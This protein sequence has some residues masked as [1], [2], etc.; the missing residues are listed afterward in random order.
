MRKH[1]CR[2]CGKIFFVDESLKSAYCT[3]C[4][5]VNDL[6]EKDGSVVSVKYDELKK[7]I[8]KIR[9]KEKNK[10]TDEKADTFI[11]LWVTVIYHGRNSQGIFSRKRAVKEINRFWKDREIANILDDAQEY[12]EK[13][14]YEQLYDSAL[15][16]YDACKTDRHYGSKL[17]D[18]VK[19]KPDEIAEKTASDIVKY[20]FRYLLGFDDIMYRDQII[21]AAWFSFDPAFPSNGDILAEKIRDLTEEEQNELNKILK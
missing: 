3:F 17:F 18:I 6:I 4:G 12:A 19:L 8:E 14:V 10:R 2:G 20:V 1:K 5:Q 15:G 21:K 9:F 7:C 11:G 16:Y 13:L